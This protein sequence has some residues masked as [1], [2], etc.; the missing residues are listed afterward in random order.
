M[1]VL[2][3][4]DQSEITLKQFAK[5]MRI[6]QDESL[7]DQEKGVLIASEIIGVSRE[8]LN[9]ANFAQL[10]DICN[11]VA[12]VLFHNN[13]PLV[14]RFEFKGVEYGFHPNLREATFGELVDLDTYCQNFYDNLHLIME[15]LYRPILK[16]QG[17]MYEIE[18]YD[19]KPS[20]KFKELGLDI[21]SGALVFFYALGSQLSEIS[22]R[23]LRGLGG[24]ELE[25]I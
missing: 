8:R 4:T 21:V 2:I 23:S 13:S 17:N 1:K 3:P 5:C 10:D 18:A 15:I 11:K 16:E 20:D 14:Q 12:T 6:S 7:D 25:L 22:Q 9:Q 24:K 19:P